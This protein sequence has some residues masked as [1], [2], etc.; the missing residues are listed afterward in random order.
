MPVRP[1][2][3]VAIRRISTPS[4]ISASRQPGARIFI[5]LATCDDGDQQMAAAGEQQSAGVAQDL[6]PSPIGP[7]EVP[8]HE[9]EAPQSHDV[10]AARPGASG[11]EREAGC[12]SPAWIAVP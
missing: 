2:L 8:V 5:E 3:V 7:D 9:D 11:Q 1:K 6:A 4:T 10:I 12:Y